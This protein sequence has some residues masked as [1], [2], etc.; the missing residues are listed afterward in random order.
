VVPGGPSAGKQGTARKFA[1]I[2]GVVALLAVGGVALKS[3]TSDS[4][5]GGASSPEAAMTAM[6][7]AAS[8]EDP[9]AMLDVL[10]PAEVGL[11]G[12]TVTNVRNALIGK[13]TTSQLG[14]VI[15]DRDAGVLDPNDLI[16]G[17]QLDFSD[18]KTSTEQL[19]DNYA[20]VSLD[21][22]QANWTFDAATFQKTV[23]VQKLFD[24]DSADIHD[25]TGSFT[26]TEIANALYGEFSNMTTPFFVTKRVDG[27]WYISLA[28]TALETT[29]EEDDLR[30]AEWGDLG[31]KKGFG[32]DSPRAAVENMVSAVTHQDIVGVIELLPPTRYDSLYRF[33]HVFDNNPTNGLDLSVDVADNKV[34]GDSRGTVLPLEGST[35]TYTMHS[36]YDESYST[37]TVTFDSDCATLTSDDYDAYYDE[38]N[39][40]DGS[41]CWSDLGKLADTLDE[42]GIDS[43][44]LSNVHHDGGFW[45]NVQQEGGRWFVDPIATVQAYARIFTDAAK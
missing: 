31:S 30:P 14:K 22:L 29:R 20:K 15:H 27:N 2:G 23:D 3:V 8:N 41:A 16:P 19:G 13:D 34:V 39:T 36:D 10:D 40:S 37:F 44:W 5:S 18:I 11:L 43:S 42:Q 9:L 17:F 12:E 4:A 32:A 28:L 33:R 7:D 26:Q 45:I 25:E 38:H 24:T 6:L 21:Q 35:F 1:L